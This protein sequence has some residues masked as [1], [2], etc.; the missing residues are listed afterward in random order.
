MRR[1]TFLLLP[2]L[3]A[4]YAVAAEPDA[5]TA[6]GSGAL[7]LAAL[8]G[9][10]SPLL[11]ATD[12]SVL[13]KFLDGQTNVAYPAGQTIAVTAAKLTCKASNVDITAHF[14]DLVF[15][16]KTVSLSGRGAHELF[17]TLAEIG[18]PSDGAAGSIFE[19]VSAL[20][21]KI[22]PNEVKQKSGGGAHCDYA[23]P[24]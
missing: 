17:A 2:L 18:V 8:V 21:C 13:A 14:C 15:G 19:A 11:G 23:P 5:Q 20:K 16:G 22:D 1:V 9:A 24:N 6:D 12:K 4:G 3:F 10:N 7:A